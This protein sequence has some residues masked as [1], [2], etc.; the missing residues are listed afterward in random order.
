MT[1]IKHQLI[2]INRH[3]Q[4]SI[5][6]H[7]SSNHHHHQ[8]SSLMLIHHQKIYRQ[9]S[10]INNYCSHQLTIYQWIFTYFHHHSPESPAILSSSIVNLGPCEPYVSPRRGVAVAPPLSTSRGLGDAPGGP[11]VVVARDA[12]SNAINA[13]VGD[14]L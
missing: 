9:Q 7:Q 1:I 6:H 12:P 11:G 2:N 5:S 8:Q 13:T 4:L 10:T 14:V 3:Q